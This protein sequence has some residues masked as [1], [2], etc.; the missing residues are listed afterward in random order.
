MANDRMF[1]RC[2][3]CGDMLPI[4]K[5]LMDGWYGA[6]TGELLQ[7]WIDK[8]AP[9]WVHETEYE[10]VSKESHAI[11]EVCYESDHDYNTKF[12]QWQKLR[13]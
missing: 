10:K 4:G 7:E 1:M 5:H 13:G 2:R 11:F 8:H 12:D 3:A 6:P 9:D